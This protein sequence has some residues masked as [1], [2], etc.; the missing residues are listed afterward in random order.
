MKSKWVNSQ[1]IMCLILI[2]GV[3]S[4]IT[5]SIHLLLQEEIDL[6]KGI[7]DKIRCLIRSRL[8]NKIILTILIPRVIAG[9]IRVLHLWKS[10]LVKLCPHLDL[11]FRKERTQIVRCVQL[12][13]WVGRRSSRWEQILKIQRLRFKKRW[14][15]KRGRDWESEKE[16]VKM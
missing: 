10:Q 11:S 16:I 15:L 3:G 6:V 7:K 2:K 12:Y 8:Y 9:T 14:A 1:I 13:Y 5:W 4:I